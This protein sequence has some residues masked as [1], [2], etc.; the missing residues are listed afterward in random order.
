[1]MPVDD[2]LVAS[3]LTTHESVDSA[4]EGQTARGGKLGGILIEIGAIEGVRYEAFSERLAPEPVIY[5]TLASQN[6][7]QSIC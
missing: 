6:L 2:F 1:M 3:K 5:G 4:I 7:N